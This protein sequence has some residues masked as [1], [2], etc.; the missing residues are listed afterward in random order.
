MPSAATAGLKRSRWPTCRMRPRD[1]GGVHQPAGGGKIRSD[2][3]FDQNVDACLQKGKTRLGVRRGGHGHD[4]GIHAAG[5]LTDVWQRLAVVF[6][7][8]P[9]RR[10]P[11]RYRRRRPSSSAATGASR[12]CAAGR[13]PRPRPR[14]C[15]A[16]SMVS[17]APRVRSRRWRCPPGPRPRS[18]SSRSSSSVRPA[19]TA[20]DSRAGLL[21]DVMVAGPATGTSNRRC[22]R[23]RDTFTS[24]SGRP[25][26][27]AAA[28]RSMASVPSMAST[29]TQARS[30]MATLCPMSKPARARAT[31]R[32]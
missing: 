18:I 28:R 1:S 30:E 9:R 7:R 32:P 11:G 3:L 19:S 20:S 25:L 15:A 29:A 27:S 4:G 23:R 22:F 5:Q 24:R 16:S 17:C 6:A 14:P 8:R 31:R 10:A 13:T 26:T 21:H 2:G 12:A